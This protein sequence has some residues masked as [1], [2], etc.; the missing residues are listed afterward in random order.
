MPLPCW[1]LLFLFSSE[2]VYT[3]YSACTMYAKNH[4]CG[5]YNSVICPHDTSRPSQTLMSINKFRF[6][7]WRTNIGQFM[8]LVVSQ[9]SCVYRHHIRLLASLVA[10]TS[11][12]AC[13]RYVCFSCVFGCA[14]IFSVPRKGPL[15]EGFLT[16]LCCGG[17]FEGSQS[18][19][20][21]TPTWFNPA[22]PGL[23]VGDPCMAGGIPSSRGHPP[24]PKA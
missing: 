23:Y 18:F 6:A 14:H 15:S 21:H 3:P 12:T 17:S 24:W 1:R 11:W 2:F 4:E 19:R 7:R 8:L 5:I 22:M 10:W 9:T 13:L 16:P 20:L